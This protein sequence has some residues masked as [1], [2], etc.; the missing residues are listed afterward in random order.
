MTTKPRV[1]KFRIRRSGSLTVGNMASA[2]RV[3][4]EPDDADAPGDAPLVLGEQHSQPKP[5]LSIPVE[6]SPDEI[7]EQI[8]QIR[9]E[10][11]T[12]RQLRMARRMAQRHSIS[13]TSDFDAVRQLRAK[14]VDPFQR[15]NILELVTPE[16][17]QPSDGAVQLPQTVPNKP[18]NLPSTE[19]VTAPPSDRSAEIAKIQHD[20]AKR[21]RRKTVALMTR[22]FALVLLPTICVGF[23]FYTIATPMY[24]TNSE[25]LIQQAEA[26][27]AGLGGLLQG[28]SL[29]GQQDSIAVQSYL[30][31]R[32]ALLRLDTDLG[33]K[34]H[35]SS[36]DI[37]PIQ[38]LPEGA[39]NEAAYALY[40]DHVRI[41]YDPTEGIV[42]MEVIATDPETSQIF[43]EALVTYAEEQVD[44]LTQRLR[45]DTMAGA[46]SSYEA[47]ELRRSAA[48]A[49]WLSIQE[50]VQQIDP[51]GETA[52]RTQQI[53][54]LES[55]RQQL[56]LEL[57]TRQSVARPNAAQVNSLESQ[58]SGIEQLIADLRASMT[59]ATENGASL[60]AKNTELRLAEE[61]YGFQTLIVQQALQQMEAAQIE[62]NRQVRYLS[63]SV[64]PIA[65]DEATYPRKF[66]NTVLAFLIFAGLYLMISLT[67]SILREQVTA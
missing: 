28:T 34:A 62:A 5:A 36:E 63:L 13:A 57:Q 49:E 30:I 54:A 15:S 33:F 11:L 47:A 21:R 9:A 56:V 8:D 66:E 59:M 20:L 50:E 10:E 32:S 43:S 46:R 51:V 61:N 52:A 4:L 18:A 16:A 3:E 27:S 22:L 45:E 44:N 64:E 24:A 23:Y 37:D 39:T 26:P 42:K 60:A 7:L 14:G 38:R 48:L 19:R 31:S 17:A 40:L 1:R 2:Q 67:T 53:S 58:I 35:F 41:S 65:P 25:F 29:A 12:G 6:L 55:Q